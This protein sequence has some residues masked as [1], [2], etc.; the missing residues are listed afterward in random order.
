[1]ES[2]D[3][4]FDV[5][6]KAVCQLYMYGSSMFLCVPSAFCCYRL[7]WCGTK[8]FQFLKR[9]TYQ[10]GNVKRVFRTWANVEMYISDSY[11]CARVLNFY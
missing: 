7:A 6:G 11:T 8:S 9:A 10:F 4:F 1:M 5:L 3:E 2:F